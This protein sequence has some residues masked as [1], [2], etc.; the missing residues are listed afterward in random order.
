MHPYLVRGPPRLPAS[1]TVLAGKIEH[2]LLNRS[3]SLYRHA[4]GFERVNSVPCGFM[5]Q[6]EV[7][8]PTCWK[9]AVL[10][11]SCQ[12]DRLLLCCRGTCLL[13]TPYSVS[14]RPHRQILHS[15]DRLYDRH[16]Q[17]IRFGRRQF[18]PHSGQSISK[19]ILKR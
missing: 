2:L 10:R 3:K 17:G 1:C 4:K 9:Q 13:N 7:L 15:D 12:S 5:Q 14:Y 18:R 19:K 16:M 6:Y 11:I 8:K